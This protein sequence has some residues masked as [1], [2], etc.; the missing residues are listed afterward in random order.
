MRR[1]EFIVGLGSVV[2]WPLAVRA[3]QPVI[4]FLSST[5][6]T[7]ARRRFSLDPFLHG[8]AETGFVEGR[9]IA[10]EY[11]WAEDKPDQLP[12]LAAELVRRQV[13]LIAAIPNAPAALAAKAATQTIPIVFVIGGD[14]VDTGIVPNLPRPGGNVTG[15]TVFTDQLAAKRLELLHELLPNASL[16]ALLMG[17]SDHITGVLKVTEDAAHRLGVQLVVLEVTGPDDFA[18]A[19]EKITQQRA[20]ALSVGT[21]PLFLSYR[22]RIIALAARHAIPTA[23]FQREAVIEG[24][25]ASYG[26]NVPDAFRRA[27]VYAGRILKGEKPGDLPVQQPTKFELLVNLKTAKAL[28]LTVPETLLVRADEVIDIS[29]RRHGHD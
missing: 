2:T 1:R 7:E 4:G 10:I 6:P 5:A 13:A 21:D 26:P 19:F 29:G 8:L 24:G 12:G 28:G 3:Q 25:L 22:D 20:A 18:A 11:R 17:P 16:I 14:P 9:N 15:F 27:G 23:Y